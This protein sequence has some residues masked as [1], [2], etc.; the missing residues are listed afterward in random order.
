[1]SDAVAN[2]MDIGVIFGFIVDVA[3]VVLA[4]KTLASVTVALAKAIKKQ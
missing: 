2:V 4:A 3:K 1:M